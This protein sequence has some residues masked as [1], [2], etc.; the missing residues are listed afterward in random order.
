M[1]LTRMSLPRRT[2]LRGLG[3]T[4]ALPLLDAMIPAATALA[5]TAAKPV[6][7]F[8]AAYS[9]NGMI[10]S[11]W[12]PS[13]DGPGFELPPILKPFEPFRSHLNVV[14]NLGTGPQRGG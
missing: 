2:F 10:M 4:L 7:R 11:Q 9:P 14:T 1:F 3:A 8:G 13:T 5:Q 12:T 6:R